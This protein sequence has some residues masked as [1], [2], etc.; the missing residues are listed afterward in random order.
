MASALR[1]LAMLRPGVSSLRVRCANLSLVRAKSALALHHLDRSS[2]V[3]HI[4]VAEGGR[5][6][7]PL[8]LGNVFA[9]M[10]KE[11]D[12]A[13]QQQK[14]RGETPKRS[15]PR[16][17]VVVQQGKHGEAPICRIVDMNEERERE[18]EQKKK[19]ARMVAQQKRMA[20]DVTISWVITEHDLD[21]KLR[22]AEEL[23]EMGG[24]LT[25][26]I[27]GKKP[28]N[29]P[30]TEERQKIVNRITQR[31]IAIP[32]VREDGSPVWQGSRTTLRFQGRKLDK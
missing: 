2:P 1:S 30:S 4:R 32:R 28:A 8:P 31:I 6:S 26:V 19:E 24:H 5:L 13:R 3:T 15:D 23:L 17:I 18:K 7:E 10:D 21:H 11:F 16:A 25:L 29:T 20:T 22:T 27:W 9:M 14:A 12:Q